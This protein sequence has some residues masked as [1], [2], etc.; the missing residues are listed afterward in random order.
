MAADTAAA[1]ADLAAG[2]RAL[3]LATLMTACGAHPPGTPCHETARRAVYD[4]L[5]ATGA[6]VRTDLFHEEGTRLV[7][8]YAT[9]G[10]TLGAAGAA[11]GSVLVGAHYDSVPAGPGAVDDA[12]AAAVMVELVRRLRAA[13]P[14]HD[15]Q[16]AIFDGEEMGL[17]GSRHH[18]LFTP[19]AERARLI[20]AVTVEMVGW[21][22]ERLVMHTFR[23]LRGGASAAAGPPGWLVDAVAR[24]GR[25]AGVEIPV[26]DPIV[27]LPYQNAV[28]N[29]RVP[30]ASDDFP[31]LAAGVPALFVSGSSFTRFYPRYHGAADTADALAAPELG[32][33]LV[34]ME[35]LVRVL[36]ARDAGPRA[37]GDDEALLLG[38]TLLPRWMLLLLAALAALPAVLLAPGRPGL[39]AAAV[40]A[41]LA[42]GGA[43]LDALS[44]VPLCAPALWAAPLWVTRRRGAGVLAG[45][46]SLAAPAASLGLFFAALARY[47]GAVRPAP[48]SPFAL[49]AVAGVFAALF[50]YRRAARRARTGPSLPSAAPGSA[51]ASRSGSGSAS[52]SKSRS[53]SASKS[54]SGSASASASTSAS[55]SKSASAS[56]AK[57]SKS[58]KSSKSS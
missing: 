4:A 52:A 28:R 24:A 5:V 10:G 36:D 22:G 57:A 46:V 38:G 6:E 44:V 50:I 45:V 18:A 3:A 54:G 55:G 26:G 27:S 19:E 42:L 40:A 25:G 1:A 21:P 12:G 49:V 58:S 43:A 56:K 20:A 32:R 14:A 47:P 35:G 39:L 7:N 37:A 48:A 13:P 51:S 41:S 15:V 17:L 16:I 33:A 23:T 31:F 11:R 8:V 2:T 9:V 53:G 29:V 34:V 30:F